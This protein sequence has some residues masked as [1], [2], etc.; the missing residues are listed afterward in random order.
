MVA[1]RSA[2]LFL[3]LLALWGMAVGLQAGASPAAAQA[4][5]GR[6]GLVVQFGD[7]RLETRCISISQTPFSGYDVL[8]NS[9]YPL[10]VDFHPSL[11]AAICKIGGQGCSAQN[12]FCD[13]PNYWA[14]WHLGKNAQGQEVW[15]YSN[16][17]ASS[18]LV[19][20]GAVEG[21]RYGPGQPPSQVVTFAEI[22]PPPTATPSRAASAT[23]PPPSPTRTA[24]P[25]P[26][27]TA[28]SWPPTPSPS[29]TA[30]P[31]S[32][33]ASPSPTPSPRREGPA[34]AIIIGA[35]PTPTQPSATPS[36][37]PS[38]TPSST[39]TAPLLSP[40]PIGNQEPSVEGTPVPLVSLS[41]SSALTLPPRVS[42]TASLPGA[43]IATTLS[44]PTATRF[45][46]ARGTALTRS[47]PTSDPSAIEEEPL[48]ETA[49]ASPRG[50][51]LPWPVIVAGV[52][53]LAALL[54]LLLAVVVALAWLYR[55]RRP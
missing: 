10:E 9:G 51:A 32:P 6:V 13:T 49:P 55:L 33:A 28:F 22:C 19:Q 4:D 27:P 1:K 31:T 30:T 48:R 43:A 3:T 18:Y 26:T 8:L 2:S 35:S 40:S 23:S 37:P 42:S 14:Y 38:P 11:G 45:P 21:W 34:T 25:S 16:I 54:F 15:Q 53:A 44:P 7:G 5:L 24:S 17:G 36:P 46:K 50:V 12:C 39:P 52:A 47:H 29:R 41:P 20:N